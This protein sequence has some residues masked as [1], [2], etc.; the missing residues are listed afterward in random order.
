VA[1]VVS[2]SELWAAL[3][4]ILAVAVF[5]R[6]RRRGRIAVP[7]IIGLGILYALAC[8]SKEHGIV[9]PLLLVAAELTIGRGGPPL[10]QRMTDL[11]PLFL[12]LLLIG[13]AFVFIRSA[14]TVG[15]GDIVSAL[16]AHESFYLRALTMLR[17]VLEWVRLFFWPASLSADYSPRRIDI[18]TG[19]TPEMLASVVIL[20]GVAALAWAS[21]RSVPVLTFAI[22]W[23][24]V[25][26]LIPSNLIV[27]TG[28]VLAERTLFLASVGVPL[29]V[30][31]AVQRV[32]AREQLSRRANAVAV[33]A[34]AVLLVLGV[35]RSASRQPVWRD[36]NVL[37]AQTIQDAP[38][39]YH[40]HLGYA[41]ALKTQKRD[42]EALDELRLAR[43]IYPNSPKLLEYTGGEYF[44]MKRCPLAISPYRRALAIDPGRAESRR[45]LVVCLIMLGR[46]KEAKSEIV[47]GLAQ[48]GARQE[49]E[50]LRIVSDS[51]EAAGS[52]ARRAPNVGQ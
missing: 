51:L 34:L 42:A 25:G 41:V 48:G 38:T 11:R 39:S 36:N 27:P 4:M 1:N 46:F 21:R 50:R 35:V 40:A 8:L 3:F 19:P 22:A 44:R 30:A 14:V 49:F 18:V 32:Y 24:V 16:F 17:V 37:F 31:A 29:G 26:L 13:V 7:T 43:L 9:L 23:V 47:H 20:L 10:R 45:G 28:F 12:A 52:L 15:T 6:Q 2:Q 33:T 5:I